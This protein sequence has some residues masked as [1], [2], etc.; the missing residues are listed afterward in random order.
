MADERKRVSQTE[1]MNESG[2]GRQKKKREKE[3]ERMI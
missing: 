2:R 1:R 3:N